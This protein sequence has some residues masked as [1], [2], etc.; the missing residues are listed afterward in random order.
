MDSP[1]PKPASGSF[2][3]G[4]RWFVYIFLGLLVVSAVLGRMGSMGNDIAYDSEETL[5]LVEINGM[6]NDSSDIV[7]QLRSY[8]R[9]DEIKGIILR[10]DSPGGAVA[11][12]QEIYEE[13]LRIRAA[14]K[15]IYASMGSLAASGGYY[16]AC[17]VDRIFANPGTLTGSIGVIMAFTNAQKLIEKIGIEPE[18][19]KSGRLKDVGSP[20]RKMTKEE[21]RYLQRVADDVHGQFIEAVSKG[22]KL[23]P[24]VTRKLAD[25]R[26]FTGREAIDLNLVD[27]LGG[28]EKTITQ[29]GKALGIEGRPRVITEQP[30]KS[31]LELILGSKASK[32]LQNSI[33][34]THFP[35]LQYLWLP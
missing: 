25:G 7:R 35:R 32:G 10:I 4:L 1:T 21:R 12:S 2:K 18:V 13:V 23:K 28:L 27:E 14:N 31:V 8:R 5:A 17:P 11:P 6:I 24:E 22:R 3:K 33:W 26:I 16:I 29:L 30:E 34:P 19:I 15:K 20:T 9:D